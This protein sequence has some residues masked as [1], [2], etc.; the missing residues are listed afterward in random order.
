MELLQLFAEKTESFSPEHATIC[1]FILNYQFRLS[2][3]GFNK[4]ELLIQKFH[5]SS[6]NFY[7]RM[8]EHSSLKIDGED[9][10]QYLNHCKEKN[11][12][13]PIKYPPT[14]KIEPELSVL[15]LSMMVMHSEVLL[16]TSSH[17]LSKE[18]FDYILQINCYQVFD[19]HF[20]KIISHQ[21]SGFGIDPNEIVKQ[22]HTRIVSI[23]KQDLT[24]K[25]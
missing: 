10:Y 18:L 20:L 17:Q 5:R 9:F 23:P 19:V 13:I 7:R 25:I 21:L 22:L 12:P 24:T 16:S 4:K 3:P 6:L 11:Y 15:L 1:Y 2:L 14:K 8:E